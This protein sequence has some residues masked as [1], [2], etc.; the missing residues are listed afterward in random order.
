V[1]GV[2]GRF[3]TL[4]AEGEAGAPKW[5]EITLHCHIGGRPTLQPIIRQCFDYAKKHDGVWFARR[6]DI[7]AYCLK[8]EGVA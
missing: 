2:P 1:G 7:A 6:R 3:D 4:Y 8:H 5:I